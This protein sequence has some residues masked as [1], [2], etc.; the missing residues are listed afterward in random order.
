MAVSVAFVPDDSGGRWGVAAE[1]TVNRVDLV[2]VAHDD[3]D[4]VSWAGL[5]VTALSG[6]RLG[7]AVA[8][9]RFSGRCPTQR[10]LRS[11]LHE[12]STYTFGAGGG[13][14]PVTPSSW[15]LNIKNL[16]LGLNS[17]EASVVGAFSLFGGGK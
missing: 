6:L 15:G 11:G 1:Y 9:T 2:A 17:E 8:C 7:Q 14:N 5:P 4:A 13:Y 3:R 12:H 10:P 16:V